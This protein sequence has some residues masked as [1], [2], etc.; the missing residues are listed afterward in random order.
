MHI[1]QRESVERAKL[2]LLADQIGDATVVP[3]VSRQSDHL[4]MMVA[5]KKW[6]KILSVV[7]LSYTQSMLFDKPNCCVGLWFNWDI[8][9]C[10]TAS[11]SFGPSSYVGCDFYIL[12]SYYGTH[13]AMYRSLTVTQM[14]DSARSS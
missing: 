7:S 8:L 13:F 6:D 9:C 3:D 4:V 1:L 5:Y 2:A 12:K 14:G 11:L 10:M